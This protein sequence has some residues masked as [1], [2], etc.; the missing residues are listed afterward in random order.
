MAMFIWLFTRMVSIRINFIVTSIE[1]FDRMRQNA[2]YGISDLSVL[3]S[4]S[5]IFFNSLKEPLLQCITK[6]YIF[7]SFGR[8]RWNAIV[9]FLSP[10]TDFNDIIYITVPLI[11]I[12]FQVNITEGPKYLYGH[13]SLSTNPQGNIFEYKLQGSRTYIQPVLHNIFIKLAVF[14]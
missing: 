13:I 1:S 12:S 3:L 10:L 9:N 5:L 8:F 7:Q 11:S 2:I 14:K 6:F 4:A